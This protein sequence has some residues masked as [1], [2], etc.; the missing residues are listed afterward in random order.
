M[1]SRLGII[2]L[3]SGLFL[4]FGCGDQKK[5]ETVAGSARV[6]E[7]P[8]FNRDS[9]YY[10]VQEQVDLGPRIPNSKAHQ[11]AFEVITSRL[12]KYGA[13]VRVQEFDTPSID[14]PQLHLKN[15][16]GAFNPESKKRVV[17]AAHWDTRPYADK[18]EEDTYA[19]FDGA[20]DGASGVG[21][22]LEIA[23]HLGSGNQPAVGVDLIFFDGEDW[24]DREDARNQ[25]PP[26][27]GYETWWCLGSQ[28]WSKNKGSYQAF[29]GILL[30]MV[31]AKNA[32]FYREGVSLE[33]APRIVDKVWATAARL[34]YADYFVTQN[35]HATTDD[36]YFVNEYAKIPMINIVH[37]QPGLGYYGD[38]HHTTKDNMSL[39][40]RETLGAVGATVLN[41]VYYEE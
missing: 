40:S 15:I 12:T 20:N 4:V 30:D 32:K 19:L 17:L 13:K 5:D 10:F 35:A 37:Y 25:V 41:V 27:P 28:Y 2:F 22:L 3:G 7:V 6:V 26:P 18:D 31:G 24:G 23:R 36:H 39:I 38:F 21:V 14:G 9:A 16:I 34:G 11:Q 29:Y 8:A 1:H 33:Y